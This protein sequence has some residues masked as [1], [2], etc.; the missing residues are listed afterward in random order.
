MAEYIN[1]QA[2]KAELR[3]QLGLDFKWNA[4]FDPVADACEVAVSIVE[5]FPAADVAPVVHGRWAPVNAIDPLSGY[6]CSN[7]RRDPP[8]DRQCEEVLTVYCPS[9]GAK[10]DKGCLNDHAML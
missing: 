5:D 4:P 1:R 8:R 9:C 10:M 2:L 3:Q 7:C 6:R